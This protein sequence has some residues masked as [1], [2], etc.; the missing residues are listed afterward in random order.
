LLTGFNHT[1]IVINDIELMARFYCD[2]LGL[3]ELKRVE[4]NAP[5]EGNHTGIPGSK[6]T[7]I[8]VGFGEGHKIEMVKYHEPG[9]AARDDDMTRIGTSHVCFNVENIEDTHAE[10]TAK[11]VEFVTDP[12]IRQIDDGTRHGIVYARDPEGNWLEFIE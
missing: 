1:G 6:R 11:G 12:I 7:L 10:L 9:S 8:I 3:T 5:P 2:D 4:S